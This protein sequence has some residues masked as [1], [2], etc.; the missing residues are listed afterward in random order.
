MAERHSDSELVA[1]TRNG[2]Q[3]AFGELVARYREVVVGVAFHRL[4]RFEEARDVAQE[5]FVKAYV[6]LPRLRRP[7]AFGSWLY[8]IADFTVLQALRRTRPEVSLPDEGTEPLPEPPAEESDLAH[9]VREALETLDEPTRLAVILH[10]V[11]GYSHA[12]VARFLG[13]TPG[14]IRTRV[15]R[16]RSRLREEMGRTMGQ[17]L[18]DNAK[19]LDF[20]E[21]F[22]AGVVA[23]MR[24]FGPP[25]AP[26]IQGKKADWTE[27]WVE[28][29]QAK[30]R[31]NPQDACSWHMMIGRNSYVGGVLFLSEVEEEVEY[32]VKGAPILRALSTPKRIRLLARL[33]MNSAPA[34]E[35]GD[36]EAD[37]ALLQETKLV[38][39]SED[40]HCTASELG[41][42][43]ALG[44]VAE[45]GTMVWGAERAERGEEGVAEM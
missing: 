28:K 36:V 43:V 10:Y 26:K 40:G 29:L 24:A 20:N 32:L 5:A 16:A 8:Q 22:L 11:S 17:H 3:A 30:L 6:N 38:K 39:R 12:E 35:L 42:M 41:R 44:V 7:E 19:Q 25:T 4:G 2:D 34:E 27:M 13:A 23:A 15:S 9:E 18:R 37:L 14:A 21:T 31:A 45:L 1:R 33:A